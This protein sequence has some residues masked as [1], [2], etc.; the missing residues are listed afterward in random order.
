MSNPEDRLIDAIDQ[1][2]SDSLEARAQ[3]DYFAPLKA[4]CELCGDEWHGLPKFTGSASCP[5][6][7]ASEED[8]AAWD[9]MF[10]R[11]QAT[12]PDIPN[13]SH[14]INSV[15]D[16]GPVRVRVHAGNPGPDGM[17]NQVGHWNQARIERDR[18][19]HWRVTGT[20]FWNCGVSATLTHVSVWD[21]QDRLLWSCPLNREY[22]V[23]AGDTFTLNDLT[24][25]M[26]V[27]PS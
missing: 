9:R 16:S 27:G 14:V 19:L 5:G 1:L 26:S 25:S 18:P 20:M 10:A 4:R 3:D 15:L 11:P 2:V 21:E 23:H 12:Q 13:P 7:W 17:R 24:M 22:Q 6:G 8:K